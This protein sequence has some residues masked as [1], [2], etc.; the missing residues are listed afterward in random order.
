MKKILAQIEKCLII[1]LNEFKARYEGKEIEFLKEYLTPIVFSTITRIMAWQGRVQEVSY[2]ADRISKEVVENTMAYVIKYALP[3]VYVFKINPKI[4]SFGT[5]KLVNVYRYGFGS[6]DV[7]YFG[8]DLMAVTIDSRT[9]VLVPP[10]VLLK[11]GITDI[12]LSYSYFKLLELEAFFTRRTPNLL[13]GFLERFYYGFLTEFSYSLD[14]ENP[15]NVNF[16]L[17]A[18]LHPFRYWYGNV[19]SSFDDFNREIQSKVS[20]LA[21]KPFNFYMP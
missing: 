7:Q 21:D 9:G 3:G 11:A 6:F 2:E 12:R 15:F 13:F 16:R 20:E 5:K 19:L 4:V 10:Y 1:D 18:N 8:N 17:V 14:A